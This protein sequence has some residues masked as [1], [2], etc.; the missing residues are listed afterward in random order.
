[1]TYTQAA[2]IYLGD[3]SSQMYEFI[4]RPRPCLFLNAHR[5]RWQND[6]SYTCWNFGTVIDDLAQLPILLAQV[7]LP[8]PYEPL[9]QQYFADTFSMTDESAAARSA[10]RSTLKFLLLHKLGQ[11]TK[12]GRTFRLPLP[13]R[14]RVG[15]EG[16]K[17]MAIPSPARGEGIGGGHHFCLGDKFVAARLICHN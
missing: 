10:R 4:R 14:E 9:Q 8:N 11:R 1:M 16:C 6:A 17:N 3:V 2:D 5:V 13:L 7:P 12:V 15:G